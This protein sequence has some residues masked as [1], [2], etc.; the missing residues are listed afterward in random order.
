ML[1]ALL[2]ALPIMLL[3]NP[4][5][6]AVY[7]DAAQALLFYWND[8]F[9]GSMTYFSS[10]ADTVNANIS[11]YK[12]L[13]FNYDGYTVQSGWTIKQKMNIDL[14]GCGLVGEDLVINSTVNLYDYANNGYG[15]FKVNNNGVLN[16]YGNTKT[17]LLSVTVYSD[18]G[19][20][21]NFYGGKIYFLFCS[22]GKAANTDNLT[23]ALPEGYRYIAHRK[24]G[25]I[26][27]YWTYNEAKAQDVFTNNTSSS[28]DYLTVEK[29][30]HTE[31]SNGV[32][33]HCNKTI[34]GEAAL[35]I[36]REELEKAK[37]SL[38][39][40][41]A[42][43]ADTATLTE[44]ITKLNTAIENAKKACNEYAAG[45]DTKLK[46]ALEEEIANN[47]TTLQ[48]AIDGAISKAS[49]DL[50]TAKQELQKQIDDNATGVSNNAQAISEAKK[51][52]QA[53]IDAANNLI[54]ALQ[55]KDGEQDTEINNLK[56]A[57]ESA[58]TDL[59]TQ[60]TNAIA[61]ASSE[62]DTAKQELQ[63]QITQNAT[64]ITN[65]AQAIADAKKDYQAKIDAANN[66]ITGLQT[67]DG[68]Q[69]TEI[70]NLKTALESAKTDL[71]TQI[72]NAIS[73]ASSELDTAKQELQKQIDDNATGVSNNAQ[74]IA[75]AKKDYQA[76]IDAAN[77]LIA[78]LQTK[79][80]EQ[81]TEI[82]NL[83][84][85]LDEAKADLNT[86]I[87]NAIAKASEDLDTAKKALQDQIDANATGVSNN[88][89]AIADAKE[90]YQTKINAAN[91]LIAA[92]QTNDEKQDTEIDNLKTALASAQTDLQTQITNA[93]AKASEDLIVAKKELQ[94]QIDSNAAGI[95]NN[96][97]SIADAKKDYQAKIDAANNLI[98]GLQTKDG[99]QDTEIA[100][101]K[102]ALDEAKEDLNT[103]ITNA[104]SKASSDLDAAKAELNATL[105]T[106][107]DKETINEKIEQLNRAIE[108][109]KILS[110]TSSNQ[111]DEALK[112][113][114]NNNINNTKAELEAIIASLATRLD[115]AENKIDK[116]ADEI[117]TLKII[118]LV[119]LVVML[120]FGACSVVV[121]FILK[122]V[123]ANNINKKTK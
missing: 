52:Y 10:T 103:K 78:G 120:L 33:V 74:A 98:S 12:S 82:N 42:K 38:N 105:S 44:E 16:Y 25:G 36:A 64:G 97:Q 32:C 106:K 9:S 24:S 41:I 110:E 50:E 80:G 75:D 86:K 77:N 116:S 101:L 6:I 123:A 62:L 5:S 31:I 108:N 69:D 92:L 115:E 85:A 2:C 111:K 60:I 118:T 51:D 53:K 58:K 57:L 107:A 37:Q 109:A 79:D 76:K 43:K 40:A 17:V 18:T 67:K 39:D 19:G 3:S 70:N 104:I 83:K 20:K 30:P 94:N 73:K 100:N 63:E 117:E 81:D 46:E 112:A 47:K 68:E 99:E 102:T 61:K 72:T 14:N 49:S 11:V 91:N 113:E 23:V 54:T 7:A 4:A 15:S 45:E 55:T 8:N 13:R 48:T 121:I 122:R 35:K 65:N 89:Q 59:Q 28:Y 96:A 29:C 56:T 88:A 119:S 1:F 22:N 87:T 34:D 27:D 71:Q 26:S 90:D 21:L 93:I 84:T 66:L 114:L 95:S